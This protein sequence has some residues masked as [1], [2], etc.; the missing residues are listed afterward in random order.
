MPLPKVTI[1]KI[2]AFEVSIRGES[3]G[4]FHVESTW[5]GFQKLIKPDSKNEHLITERTDEHVG[6]FF[7]EMF[8]PPDDLEVPVIYA[9]QG[10]AEKLTPPDQRHKDFWKALKKAAESAVDIYDDE[11]EF[12]T[13]EVLDYIDSFIQ[14]EQADSPSE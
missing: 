6:T 10:L 5:N 2:T 12:E 11:K 3:A 4:I 9:T 8:G 1:K 7:T 13:R 14:S